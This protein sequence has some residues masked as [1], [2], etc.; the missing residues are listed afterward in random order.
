MSLNRARRICQR[1]GAME[2]GRLFDRTARSRALGQ[3]GE[4]PW[5][6]ECPGDWLAAKRCG[7]EESSRGQLCGS[8]RGAEPACRRRKL[9]CEA[10][11]RC[12][13]AKRA[14]YPADVAKKALSAIKVHGGAFCALAMNALRLAPGFGAISPAVQVRHQHHRRVAGLRVRRRQ[15]IQQRVQIMQHAAAF[16]TRSIPATGFEV[17]TDGAGRRRDPRGW[18]P[19]ARHRCTANSRTPINDGDSRT[20]FAMIVFQA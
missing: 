9:P 7:C 8:V 11:V 13:R 10:A 12:Q 18:C 16:T 2:K 20:Q 19:A 4:G 17:Q 5:W 14:Q 15:A 1:A 6:A 3:Q